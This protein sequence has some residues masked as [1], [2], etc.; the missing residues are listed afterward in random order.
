M[1]T[2][3]ESLGVP[4][5]DFSNPPLFTQD[6]N[7]SSLIANGHPTRLGGAYIAT[8]LLKSIALLK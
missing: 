8:Q 2:A 4:F 1:R 5:V 7:F 3:A 6:N